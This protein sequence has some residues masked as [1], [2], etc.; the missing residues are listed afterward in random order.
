MTPGP[1]PC[2]VSRILVTNVFLNHQK[3]HTGKTSLPWQ[4]LTMYYMHEKLSE[5]KNILFGCSVSFLT[6]RDT[7]PLESLALL[8]QLRGK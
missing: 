7:E 4:L 3:T 8:F 5:D 2:P 6:Q 1:S